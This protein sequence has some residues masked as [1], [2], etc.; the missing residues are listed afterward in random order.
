M[1]STT[2]FSHPNFVFPFSDE[3]F[4]EVLGQITHD[5]IEF[6]FQPSMRVLGTL[7]G[8]GIQGWACLW[9]GRVV[10]RKLFGFFGD[11]GFSSE[12][13]FGFSFLGEL[14]LYKTKRE[15]MCYLFLP[16]LLPISLAHVLCFGWSS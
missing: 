6:P 3:N 16:L 1:L 2:N 8:L 11:F 10:L 5:F 7:G 13:S 15:F 4:Y 12:I 9:V 14:V